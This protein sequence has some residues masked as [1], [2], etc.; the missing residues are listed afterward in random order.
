MTLP[1]VLWTETVDGWFSLTP[2]E[3]GQLWAALRYADKERVAY[4]FRRVVNTRP[5]SP[6]RVKASVRL[7]SQ[8]L[9][10]Q[11]FVNALESAVDRGELDRYRGSGL[12]DKILAVVQSSG[13]WV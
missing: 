13:A 1:P 4:L 6:S 7:V 9:T 3:A 12:Q 10:P 2:E 5:G 11:L 8:E